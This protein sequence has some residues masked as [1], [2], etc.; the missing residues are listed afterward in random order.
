[1]IKDLRDI[2]GLSQQALADRAGI[3][4]P[5]V[6]R[7]EKSKRKLTKEWATKLAPHLH[8]T[9]EF[10]IFGSEGDGSW[11]SLLRR[12]IKVAL[13]QGVM[14]AEINEE[15]GALLFSDLADTAQQLA[16]QDRES[17]ETVRAALGKDDERSGNSRGRRTSDNREQ[18]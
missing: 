14:L 4:Q 5:Q 10:L 13:D 1:M 3:S 12:S 9:P 16:G 15:L 11:Q 7:L 17:G 2:L 18:R 8:T 6:Q